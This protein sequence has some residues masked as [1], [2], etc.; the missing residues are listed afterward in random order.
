MR[1]EIIRE[2]PERYKNDIIRMWAEYLPDTAPGRYEWLANGNPAGNTIWYFALEKARNELAGVITVIPKELF[3]DR[4][5]IRVGILGD[6]MIEKKYRVFGPTLQLPKAAIS[7]MEEIGFEFIYTIPNTES[8]IVME[9][10]G[11]RNIGIEMFLVRPIKTLHILHKYLPAALAKPAS[12]FVDKIIKY[13]SHDTYKIHDDT[14]EEVF[15]FDSS[16]DQL[17]EH[18]RGE[19]I[20]LIVGD[21]SSEYLNWR[22]LKNPEHS[23]RIIAYKEKGRLLGYVV[24]Y[25]ENYSLYIYDVFVLREKDIFSLINKIV[26]IAEES[27]CNSVSI[28]ILDKNPILKSLKMCGF[29]NKEQDAVTVLYQGESKRVVNKW[30]FFFCDHNL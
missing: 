26:R 11:F 30:L 6:F 22:Y 10:I 27:N 21:H 4:K 12:I 24:F 18:K 9:R 28:S 25:I 5:K 1:F 8:K 20:G 3:L 29:V 19:D 2:N 15:E 7:D 16:F 14:C 13:S 23:F 17:W